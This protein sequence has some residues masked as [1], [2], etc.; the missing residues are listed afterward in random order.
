MEGTVVAKKLRPALAGLVLLLCLFSGR[1]W[2]AP[3]NSLTPEGEGAQSY[4]LWL[5]WSPE[6]AD[7]SR[8]EAKVRAGAGF[9]EAAYAAAQSGGKRVRY[10]LDCLRADELDPVVFEVARRLKV[11]ETSTP[12]ALAKGWAMVMRTTMAFRQQGKALFDQGRHAQAER[13]FM[14]DVKLQPRDA[15]VW[16][17]LALSRAAQNDLKGALAAI[18]RALALEPGNPGL[19]QDKATMLVYAGRPDSALE[20]YRKAAEAD[21]DN[22]TVQS[23]MAWVMS[24]TK[25]DLA[26]AQLLAAK[27]VSARPENGR[28]WYTLGLVYQARGNLEDAV[29]ALGQASSLSGAPPEVLK[30]LALAKRELEQKGGSAKTPPVKSPPPAPA[31]GQAKARPEAAAVAKAEPP[32]GAPKPRPAEGLAPASVHAKARPEAAAAAKAEPPETTPKPRPAE[33]PAAAVKEKSG[34]GEAYLQVATALDH[35]MALEEL[36]PLLRAGYK[37]FVRDWKDSKGRTWMAFYLGPFQDEKAAADLGEELKK[38]EILGSCLVRS[39]KPGFRERLGRPFEAGLPEKAG[40]EKEPAQASAPPGKMAGAEKAGD[41]PD[42]APPKAPART[43]APQNASRPETGPQAAPENKQTAEPASPEKAGQAAPRDEKP[44]AGKTVAEKPA[45]DKAAPEKTEVFLQVATLPTEEMAMVESR[46]LLRAGYHPF[47]RTWRDRRGR[48][49]EVVYLGPLESEAKAL[50]LARSLKARRLIHSHDIRNLE[51]GFRK[52][53]GRPLGAAQKERFAPEPA[54]K[55]A[56]RSLKPVAPAPAP[57]PKLKS[58]EPMAQKPEPKPAT[59]LALKKP[60][61]LKMPEALPAPLPAAAP[62]GPAATGEAY[63]VVSAHPDRARA[64]TEARRFHK[65]GYRARLSPWPRQD[66]KVWQ[67]VL[68]GP[69]AGKDKALEAA[70]QLQKKGMITEYEL[71][72]RE[73]VY[74]QVKS[75][76]TR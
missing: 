26:K 11:G 71:L 48:T 70:R 22:P 76:P 2:A 52:S 49:W 1:V 44:P 66:G 35:K 25:K 6:K 27:A 31:A 60:A 19:M 33:P 5:Y 65:A 30:K 28:F 21:P 9:T 29:K 68:L 14:R 13:A 72:V 43:P 54:E 74:P 62:A 7:V 50:E 39:M 24:L 61:V 10:S 75:A 69:F 36:M 38:K 67:R 41:A 45:G 3:V 55:P 12:F 15:A 63:L 20:L 16:H 23:N 64:Y 42:A 18:D 53:R 17:L 4:C 51:R 32:E 46:G 56:S 59:P 57:E 8:L 40:A 47:V 58:P 37:P 73:S 34:S